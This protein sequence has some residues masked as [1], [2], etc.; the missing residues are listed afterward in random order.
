M[1]KRLSLGV[2]V[3]FF[4]TAVI[5]EAHPGRLDSN[6]GHYNRKTGEYH[7][8]RGGGRASGSSSTKTRSGATKSKVKRSEAAQ[9]KAPASKRLV[10]KENATYQVKVRSGDRNAITV[11]FMIGDGI[12]YEEESVRFIGVDT[13]ILTP[14]E[15]NQADEF[16]KKTL[17]GRTAW[18]QTDAQSR[19][20]NGMV[21][22]YIWTEKPQKFD[23]EQEIRKKMFNAQMI[24]RGYGRAITKHPNIR[25]TNHLRLFQQE[26]QNNK[27]GITINLEK[28]IATE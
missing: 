13:R 21:L 4:G 26:A 18:L 28:A 10:V 19:D 15:R 14:Q 2:L 22:G 20:T 24:S 1:L 8:H 5:S 9:V 25:Y 7:Y 23:D 11:A 27:K 16:V 17:A 6:G 3:F 12:N